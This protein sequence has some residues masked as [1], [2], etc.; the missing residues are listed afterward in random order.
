MFQMGRSPICK[1]S[2]ILPFV[3]TPVF[4]ALQMGICNA[5]VIEKENMGQIG[6]NLGMFFDPFML[7]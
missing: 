3:P 7:F 2:G 4:W 6:H 5:R 1:H